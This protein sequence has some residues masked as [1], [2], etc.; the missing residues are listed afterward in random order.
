M[1][2]RRS[3]PH[4]G[5]GAQPGE[6]LAD[7]A[8]VEPLDAPHG[9]KHD[10]GRRPPLLERE[11]PKGA[12]VDAERLEQFARRHQRRGAGDS[13]VSRAGRAP[14]ARSTVR[15]AACSSRSVQSSASSSE[16][17]RPD[18]RPHSTKASNGRTA[19]GPSRPAERIPP[20]RADLVRAS[21]RYPS[22]GT[23]AVPK[24]GCCPGIAHRQRH[25]DTP[26]AR[27]TTPRIV[28]VC[29]ILSL[30]T[31]RISPEHRHAGGCP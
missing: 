7:V 18:R 24:A 11:D 31:R 9:R 22:G 29:E 2:W 17:R 3:G 1:S 14:R 30:A 5:G 27:A 12:A 10:R 15:V 26:T 8:L 21:R 4:L 13:S 28:R 20:P 16:R 23:S 6:H 25:S 19:R